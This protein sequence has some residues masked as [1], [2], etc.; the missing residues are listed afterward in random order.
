MKIAESNETLQTRRLSGQTITTLSKGLKAIKQCFQP[1]NNDSDC[2]LPPNQ[3]VSQDDLTPDQTALAV[4]STP[5]LAMIEQTINEYLKAY[6]IAKAS[7]EKELQQRVRLQAEVIDSI[8]AEE[9]ARASAEI[10]AQ[11]K[12]E[13]QDRAHNFAEDVS[14]AGPT[15]AHPVVCNGC[16]YIRH[17]NYLYCYDIKND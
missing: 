13:A 15:W 6:E 16:L 2:G 14:P 4:D 3:A 12:N 7:A 1:K 5:D 11:A 17:G 8:Q 10:L 9:K